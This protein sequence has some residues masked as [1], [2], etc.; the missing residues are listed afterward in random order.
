[1]AGKHRRKARL[2]IRNKKRV[3]FSLDLAYGDG[4]NVYFTTDPLRAFRD[5]NEQL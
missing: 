5:R 4:L 2:V 3:F 1:M